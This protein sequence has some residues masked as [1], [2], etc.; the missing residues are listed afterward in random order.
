MEIK[1]AQKTVAKFAEERGWNINI[2]SHRGEHL[3][4]EV[5]KLSEHILYKEGVTIKAPTGSFE[6]QIGDVFFSLLS[7]ANKAKVDIE[8][9]LTIALE[10]DKIKYPAEKTK[11]SQIKAYKDHMRNCLNEIMNI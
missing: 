9:Q 5:G 1:E 3:V 2:L 7:L 10:Q 4:R 11:D 6:K 8:K